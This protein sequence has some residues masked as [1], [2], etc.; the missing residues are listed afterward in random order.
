MFRAL[1]GFKAQYHYLTLRVASDFD[2]WKVILEGPGVTIQG[3]RQFTEVKAKE[4]AFAVAKDYIHQEKHED[5]P[6]LESLEW[7]P[8]EPG[9]WLNWRP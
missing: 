6:A 4:H 2:E 8:F 7:R 1:K 3:A 5:L 9:E